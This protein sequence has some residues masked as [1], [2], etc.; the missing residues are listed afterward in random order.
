MYEHYN[1]C[2]YDTFVFGLMH[3]MRL[4]STSGAGEQLFYEAPH[5]TRQLIP[6]ATTLYLDWSSPLT[7]VLDETVEGVWSRD[8]DL[9]DINAVATANNIPLVAAA[10]DDGGLVRLFKYP[11]Q[12]SN[13]GKDAVRDRMTIIL[14]TTIHNHNLN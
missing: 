3:Y 5:C 11:C 13:E 1:E 6:D 10:C 14:A 8:M 12:V 2:V 9:T 7:C 4:H